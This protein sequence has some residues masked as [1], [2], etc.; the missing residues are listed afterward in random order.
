MPTMDET[1]AIVE[2]AGFTYKQFIDLT[3]IGYEY[4]YLFCFVK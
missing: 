1:V 4:Q 3:P 2:R